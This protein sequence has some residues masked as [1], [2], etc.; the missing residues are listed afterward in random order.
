MNISV[1]PL[2]LSKYSLINPHKYRQE[3]CFA[4]TQTKQIHQLSQAISINLRGS[5]FI[6]AIG[7][8]FN[9]KISYK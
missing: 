7:L 2:T 6:K 4:A 8:I 9:V 3:K 1:L 5:A